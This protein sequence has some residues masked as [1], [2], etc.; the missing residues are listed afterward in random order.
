M[1][2]QPEILNSLHVKN[3]FYSICTL[4]E[5]W[6]GYN[7]MVLLGGDIGGRG[8]NILHK[9]F[10][11]MNPDVLSEVGKLYISF[12]MLLIIDLNVVMLYCS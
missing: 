8:V 3:Q 1:Y 2:I 10:Q 6:L 11:Q 7:E 5:C 12:N 4:I 9:D